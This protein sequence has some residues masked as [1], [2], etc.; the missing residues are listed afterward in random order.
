MVY[1]DND[2]EDVTPHIPPGYD[3]MKH[4]IVFDQHSHTI[5]SD[6]ALT[7]KQNVEWHIAM[8]Y[9]VLA[10]TDHNNM[11]HLEKIEKIRREYREQGILILSGIEITTNRIHLNLL[12]VSNW[13]NKIRYKTSDS[14]IIETINRA[15]D[16]DG[17]VVCDHIPWSLYEFKMKNHPSRETLLEW[18][19]DYIEIINDD[20]KP[21]NVFDYESYE[22]CNEH[23]DRIGMITG[24]D[25][26]RPDGLISG[27]VHGWTILNIK[28]FTEEILLEELRKKQTDII[29]S[30]TP[31]LDPVIHNKK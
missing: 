7:I 26:H 21:E 1:S 10:I 15:H 5:F 27:G 23:K 9:N 28:E 4:N 13:E 11:R 18:G 25:M 3:K 8:G 30:K 22:F 2:W 14:L 24:T 17:I 6:G 31:Y 29:Y 19:I 20:S 12:G 16:E